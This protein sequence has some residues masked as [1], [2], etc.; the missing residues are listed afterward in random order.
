MRKSQQSLFIF[1]MLSMMYHCL[2]PAVRLLVL[3]VSHNQADRACHRA[4]AEMGVLP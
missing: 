1:K 3:I 4:S 2:A